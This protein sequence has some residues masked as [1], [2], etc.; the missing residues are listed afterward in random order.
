M[1][2]SFVAGRLVF[3][4]LAISTAFIPEHVQ[5]QTS[6]IAPKL[7][8]EERPRSSPSAIGWETR[9]KTST[10]TASWTNRLNAS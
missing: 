9:R 4:G 5:A 6:P 8:A 1:S 7:S 3:L 2:R 10:T